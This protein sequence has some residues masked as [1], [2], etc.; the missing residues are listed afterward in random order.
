MFKVIP[1]RSKF[2]DKFFCWTI[3]FEAKAHQVV[4]ISFDRISSKKTDSLSLRLDMASEEIV[5]SKPVEQVFVY[6]NDST[7]MS[8]EVLDV[9]VLELTAR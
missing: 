2:L 6:L 1:C 8:H 3:N 9:D 5:L 4:V 7:R